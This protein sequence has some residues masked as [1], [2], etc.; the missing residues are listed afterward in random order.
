MPLETGSLVIHCDARR[1][2]R[3]AGQDHEHPPG[4]LPRAGTQLSHDLRTAGQPSNRAGSTG[5]GTV[6]A[7]PQRASQ[8]AYESKA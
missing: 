3:V 8:A 6:V 1:T 7:S 5:L 4:Q 2:G